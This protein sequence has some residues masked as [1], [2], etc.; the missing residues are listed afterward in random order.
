M[1]SLFAKALQVLR[2][3]AE[4]FSML[5][6]GPGEGAPKPSEHKAFTRSGKP[7]YMNQDHPGHENYSWRDH[8]DAASYHHK[9]GSRL[10]ARAHQSDKNKDE[11]AVGDRVEHKGGGGTGTYHKDSISKIS[12]EKVQLTA[13]ADAHTSK[14]DWHKERAQAM[15]AA[16][17]RGKSPVEIYPYVRSIATQTVN[18]MSLGAHEFKQAHGDDNIPNIQ[19][20]IRM[21]KSLSERAQM[22]EFGPGH[23][24]PKE[25]EKPYE[26]GAM[27]EI[28]KDPKAFAGSN[29]ADDRFPTTTTAWNLPVYKDIGHPGHERY[30]WQDH[31]D[32]G[33]F[34]QLLERQNW[35][36]ATARL[37]VPGHKHKAFM[38][39]ARG[40][41]DKAEWHEKLAHSLLRKKLV[42]EYPKE[43][44]AFLAHA[45]GKVVGDR[46]NSD[47]FK[48]IIKAL[49]GWAA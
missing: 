43:A 5:E 44:H 36:Q 9:M 15:L 25:A 49:R 16:E 41:R 30:S 7:I 34:H 38:E 28:D 37:G 40:H 18:Q 14:G 46:L 21:L 31:A 4:R 13:H 10:F 45:V 2:K 27:L 33:S 8:V 3:G 12:P 47:N 24:I 1:S 22:L 11:L 26:R 17:L 35:H 42:G 32:A 48:S 39:A 6:L 20:A 19:K 29:L 23:E